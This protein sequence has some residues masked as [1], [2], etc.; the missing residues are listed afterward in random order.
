M[1]ATLTITHHKTERNKMGLD[2]SHGCWSGS[3]SGFSEWRIL[4]ARA[5]GFP[6][7]RSM[8]GFDGETP[9]TEAPQTPLALLLKHSDCDGELE[10]K[11][12]AAIADELQKLM[13]A[14]EREDDT[15]LSWVPART[16]EFIKGLRE[17]AAAG[18]NVEFH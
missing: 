2:T 4:I 18:E 13:P 9:W 16:R 15:E 11:D 17:A 10:S 12:C 3:Y 8:Q 1:M 7:L 14:L 6:P 5:A